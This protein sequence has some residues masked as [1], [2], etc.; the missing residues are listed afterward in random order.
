MTDPF[1]EPGPFDPAPPPS[2]VAGRLERLRDDPDWR[3]R[4]GADDLDGKIAGHVL[5]TG[6]FALG[7]PDQIEPGPGGR[8]EPW[9]MA[10]TIGLLYSFGHPEL[11]LFGFDPNTAHA[12]F[13]DVIEELRAGRRFESGERSLS[14]GQ[15]ELRWRCL[16]VAANQLSPHVGYALAFHRFADLPGEPAAVQLVWPDAANRLPGEPGCEP[17]C[18]RQP[19]LDVPLTPEQE[20]AFQAER[21]PN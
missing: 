17:S 3:A 8:P 19:R 1:L 11:I 13:G 16:P 21:G 18:A 5:E 12:I 6:W 7:V 20:A 14:N 4:R 9:P 15:R 10:Y 2:D